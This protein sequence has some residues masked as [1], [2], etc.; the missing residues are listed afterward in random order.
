MRQALPI[1]QRRAAVGSPPNSNCSSMPRDSIS[2]YNARV[3]ALQAIES[4]V[5]SQSRSDQKS[6]KRVL[7]VVQLRPLAL[8]DPL[9]GP[10]SDNLQFTNAI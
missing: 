9:D 5:H 2:F 4:R 7:E 3:G 1:M 8:E 6:K 10:Q